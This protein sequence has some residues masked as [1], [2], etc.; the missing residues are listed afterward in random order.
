[1]APAGSAVSF[2]YGTGAK[3]RGVEK[4][5]RSLKQPRGLHVQED[6]TLLVADY[7]NHCVVRFAPGDARGKVV[8]GEE[9]KRLPD[10]D[11]MKDI[12]RPL[13]APEGEGFLL[14]QPID[15]CLGPEGSVW[16]LDNEEARVQGFGGKGGAATQV[17]PPPS[18]SY[19]KSHSTP[20]AVKN[21]RSAIV[22]PDGA[23]VICDS[24]SHRVL[25]YMPVGSPEAAEKPTVLAG[26]AN[27]AGQG[28]DQLFFPSCVAYGPDGALYVSDTNN[29]RVQ[30]FAPG[31]LEG[32]TVAGSLFGVAG[33]G[34]CDL[35]M[36]T[37]IA[38]ERDGSL[39]VADRANARVLRFAAGSKGGDQG[40]EVAGPDILQRPWGL[41]VGADGAVY[42][43]DER[44]ASV[45]KLGGEEAP[46]TPAAAADE[47]DEAEAPKVELLE[48][49]RKQPLVEEVPDAE[50]AA[51][52]A[53]PVAVKGSHTELD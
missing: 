42:V 8:A 28:P 19:L 9:G 47:E 1:M 52:P 37:G 20:E 18:G 33:E 31:S 29:H 26:T 36:P 7:G 21:P 22:A 53:A 32:T 25:R 5:R 10:I 16:V 39:L 30:R 15:V 34:L 43:S 41:C 17:A 48:P 40:E 12:D 49:P 24:W 23:V 11:I 3:G 46:A 44:L 13:G 51:A 38:F 27:S 2:R 4:G 50:A 45:L 14:K 35:N 6:G